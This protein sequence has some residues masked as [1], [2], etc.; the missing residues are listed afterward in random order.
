MHVFVDDRT[1]AQGHHEGSV[2]IELQ[3]ILVATMR[4]DLVSALPGG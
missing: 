1:L 4:V 2:K 3:E